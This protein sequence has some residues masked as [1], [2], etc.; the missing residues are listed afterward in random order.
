MKLLLQEILR[1]PLFWLLVFVSIAPA[2]E[3]LKPRS[4]YATFCFINTRD[5]SVGCSV[6][7]CHGISRGVDGTG[8]F[9]KSKCGIA[10]VRAQALRDTREPARPPRLT[11][12]LQVACRHRATPAAFPVNTSRTLFC[13]PQ[14]FSSPAPPESSS[15]AECVSS[16][17]LLLWRFSYLPLCG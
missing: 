1:N 2:A 7:S 6:K 3:K 4:A 12:R 13:L 10:S 17:S 5:S 14:C 11:P 9:R 15:S 8:A 16:H